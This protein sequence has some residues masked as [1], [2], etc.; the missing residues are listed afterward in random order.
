MTA[1]A[2][3][4]YDRA[5]R[6]PTLISSKRAD[7]NRLSTFLQTERITHGRRRN[8]GGGSSGRSGTARRR[9]LFNGSDQGLGAH[10]GPLVGDQLHDPHG[11]PLH[12]A[13]V[14]PRDRAEAGGGVARI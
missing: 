2:S 13:P 4:S 1:D 8:Q 12:L 6:L 3:G 5:L 10:A 14:R 9:R 7:R 11:G